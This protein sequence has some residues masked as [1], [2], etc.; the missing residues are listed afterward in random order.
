MASTGSPDL[1]DWAVALVSS[2]STFFFASK[3]TEKATENHVDMTNRLHTTEQEIETNKAEL[4]R[5]GVLERRHEREAAAR[6]KEKNE[7]TT[8]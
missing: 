1:P 4:A 6:R 5:M 7:S 3:G 8:D 2:I